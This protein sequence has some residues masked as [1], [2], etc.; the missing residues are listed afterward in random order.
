M[1]KNKKYIKGRYY[2]SKTRKLLEKEGYSVVRSAGSKGPADLVAFNVEHFRLIQVKAGKSSFG[3]E[4][5]RVFKKMETPK[6]CTK[7]LWAWVERKPPT[8]EIIHGS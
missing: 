2:E 3:K 4:E 8:I 7:E 6:N 1:P 5:R